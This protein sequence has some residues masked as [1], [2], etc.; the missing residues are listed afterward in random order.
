MSR[1]RIALEQPERVLDG[2]DEGPV[3]V[4]QFLPGAPSENDFGHASARGSTVFEVAAE[5]VQRDAVA[6]RQLGQAGFD[7]LKRRGV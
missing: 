2:V 7:G 3:E 6:P 4:E 1:V 5:L